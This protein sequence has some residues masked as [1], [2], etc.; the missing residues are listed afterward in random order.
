MEFTLSDEHRAIQ[1]SVRKFAHNEIAPIAAQVDEEDS[2]PKEII[3]KMGDLGLILFL[4]CGNL[5]LLQINRFIFSIS[6][7]SLCL[8]CAKGIQVLEQVG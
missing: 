5:F 3:K 6:W 7:F 4:R 8:K 2:F 1:E